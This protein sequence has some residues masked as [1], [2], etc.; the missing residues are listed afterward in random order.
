[1]TK[2]RTQVLL[3]TRQFD[4]LSRQARQQDISVSELVRRMVEK[5]LA[6]HSDP[7]GLRSLRGAFMGPRL[8]NADMDDAIY[9]G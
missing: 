7:G 1:V 5:E 2:H 3:E 6:G 8:T 4:L 9:G